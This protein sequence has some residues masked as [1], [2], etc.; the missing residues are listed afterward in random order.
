M[1]DLLKKT[2]TELQKELASAQQTLRELRFGSAGSKA[3]NTAQPRTLKHKI[4]QITT[5]L[6]SLAKNDKKS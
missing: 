6:A 4:A 3:K 1:K 2:T 5:A